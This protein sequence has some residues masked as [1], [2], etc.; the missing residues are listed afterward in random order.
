MARLLLNSAVSD[1]T[2][3]VLKPGANRIGRHPTND[4]MLAHESVSSWH[5]EV[6]LMEDQVVVRDLGSTNGTYIESEAVG[7]ACLMGGQTLHIGEVPMVLRDAPARVALP[8]F[9]GPPPPPKPTSLPD[10]TPCCSKHGGAP[11]EFHCGKCG[12][13]FCRHCVRQLRISGH[14]PHRF[15]PE[16]DGRCDWIPHP[17]MKK[18]RSAFAGFFGALSETLHLKK[19]MPP[20]A[21]D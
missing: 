14:K 13:Y 18:K 11:G 1:I 2:E 21:E 3:I 12:Q 17:H 8:D 20:R 10:G 19:H 4:V 7:E 15:C 5:C 9:R 6:W 16:C